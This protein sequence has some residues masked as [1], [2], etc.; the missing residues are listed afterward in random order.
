MKPMYKPLAACAIVCMAFFSGSCSKDDNVTPAPA[1]TNAELYARAMADAMITDSSE[2]SHELLRIKP[3]NAALQWKTINGRSYV[4]M[5]TFM[6]FPSSY[7]EGDSITNT[8]GESWLFAPSQMKGRVGP[9]FQ[10]GSDTTLRVCQVLGLPPVNPKTNTH[11]AEIWVPASQLY[12]PAGNPDITTNT[13]NAIL[14]NNAPVSYAGWFNSY[15]IFAYY[16]PLQGATDFHFPWTR[17]GY[18]Y[19]WAPGANEMGLSEFVLQPNSGI[20]VE[21]VRKVADYF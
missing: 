5:A 20:W 16:R 9:G 2:V 6:R 4:L 10:A 15:I 8:W 14:V 18:T 13:T 7:P 1:P 11:I 12:R 21:K 19:D 17:L 3:D